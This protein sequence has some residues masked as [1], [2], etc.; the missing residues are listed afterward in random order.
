MMAGGREVNQIGTEGRSRG[1]KISGL[2]V[3]ETNCWHPGWRRGGW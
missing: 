2:A 1:S 3:G